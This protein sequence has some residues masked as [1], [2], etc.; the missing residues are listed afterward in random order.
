M[1]FARKDD[2]TPKPGAHP[3]TPALAPLLPQCNT[4]EEFRAAV[5]PWGLHHGE[6]FLHLELDIVNRCNIQCVMC[7]HSLEAT[8]VPVVYMDPAV[9]ASAAAHILPYA[10]HMSLSLGNEPLMSPHFEAM[11]KLAAPYKVPNVNFFTNGLLLNERKVAAM[12]ECGVTQICV[13][14]DGAQ[15]DTYNA[16]RRGGE[17]NELIENVENL[18]RQRNAA[19]SKTPKVRFDVVL[20]RRNI[21]ELPDIV[22][23]AA[24]LGVEQL[25]FR[26]MVSFDGLDMGHESLVHAKAVSNYWLA[27]ALEQ[28]AELGLEVQTRPEFFADDGTEPTARPDAQALPTPYCPF[29]FFHLSMGPGGHV[30]PCPHSHGQGPYGQVSATT[31]LDQIW[32]NDKFTELRNRILRNDPPDMCRRCPYLADHYPNYDSLFATRKH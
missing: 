28:A 17:F 31:P 9:F 20:M 14:I 1:F 4:I 21:R 27:S 22:R 12:I 15:R 29:P 6:R 11:L 13:S 18:I 19:G 16:I 8:R 25:S 10:S 30:L 24:R 7:Y 23:L 32:M 5:A 3:D 26:H 2:K